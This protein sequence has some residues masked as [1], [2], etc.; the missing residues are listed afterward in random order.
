L[1]E[2]RPAVANTLTLADFSV[3]AY[4]L[5]SVA[6]YSLFSVADYSLRPPAWP[7][8]CAKP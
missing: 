2:R 5:F 6:D 3:A 4:S 8:P 1:S 7:R